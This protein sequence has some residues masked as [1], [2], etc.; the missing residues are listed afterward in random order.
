MNTVHT[1][2]NV[3]IIFDVNKDWRFF[4]MLCVQKGWANPSLSLTGI[5]SDQPPTSFGF[6]NNSHCL[7]RT[8]L[9]RLTALNCKTNRSGVGGGKFGHSALNPILSQGVFFLRR[10]IS[11]I[12]LGNLFS[13]LSN[14][15][16]RAHIVPCA[17]REVI[18]QNRTRTHVGVRAECR[19]V[20]VEQFDTFLGNPRW[21]T[22]NCA[23]WKLWDI[24]TQ[25]SE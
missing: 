21:R 9:G 17:L 11:D 14:V 19:K 3:G 24:E 20:A 13:F 8:T 25:M 10:G 12:E 16:W 22:E 5:G 1:S 6:F 18:F 7:K 15:L 23:R 4:R 2:N